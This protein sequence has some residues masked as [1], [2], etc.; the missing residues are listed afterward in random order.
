[1]PEY[2]FSIDEGTIPIA[3]LV[4]KGKPDRIVFLDEQGQYPAIKVNEWSFFPL[5]ESRENQVSRVFISGKAGAGKSTLA[6]RMIKEILNRVPGKR[7]YVFS[8]HD[9]DASLDKDLE[10]VIMRIDPDNYDPKLLYNSIVV[11]DDP[12]SIQPT[13]KQKATH[14]LAKQVLQIGRKHDIDVI[15][16]NHV[17][18]NYQN[19]KTVI[20]ECNYYVIFPGSGNNGQI[21]G[22]IK[23]YCGYK[24]S[25]IKK[26]VDTTDSRWVCMFASYPSF[27][28][29]EKEI[30]FPLKD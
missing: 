2:K 4:C 18:R 28:M 21:E 24:K 30:Y 25:T 11:F 3:H 12:D 15:Y 19:T 8:P 9:K 10:K 22:F 20:Q 23:T 13:R 1:M 5:L 29:T 7:V 26:I 27:I 16:I 14:E 6:N 17:L